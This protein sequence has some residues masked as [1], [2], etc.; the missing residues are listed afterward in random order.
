VTNDANVLREWAVR[1]HG[2]IYAPIWDVQNDVLSGHLETM[3]DKFISERV[4][5]FANCG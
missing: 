4:G 2:V 3:L 5:L 1:G